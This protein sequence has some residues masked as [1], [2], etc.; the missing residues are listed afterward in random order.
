MQGRED[1]IHGFGALA[2]QA[3]E[4]RNAITMAVL[5]RDPRMRMRPSCLVWHE[6]TARCY[7]SA[8]A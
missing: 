3:R 7:A 1:L 5:A 4:R 2:G 6:H 8:D